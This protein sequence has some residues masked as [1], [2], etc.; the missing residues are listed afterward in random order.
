[1]EVYSI[2]KDTP[3]R[4]TNGGGNNEIY[5][6]ND[7]YVR[8]F[9]SMIV[10]PSGLRFVVGKDSCILQKKQGDAVSEDY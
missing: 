4:G 9:Y 5:N 2:T 8:E 10:H 7:R 1:L 3:C 6:D